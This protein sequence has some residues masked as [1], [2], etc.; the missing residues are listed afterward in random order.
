MTEVGA[1]D[2]IVTSPVIREI[3][4]IYPDAHV[5]ILVYPR[6]LELAEYCPYVNAIVLNDQKY[7]SQN[8]IE[9]YELNMNIARLFLAQRFDICFAT[10]IHSRTPLLMYMSGAKIRITSIDDESMEQFNLTNDLTRYLMRLSTHLF[11]YNTYGYHRVDRHLS[12]IEN[13]LHLPITNRNTEIWCK[14]DEVT[15]AK[16]LLRRASHPIHAFSM[17]SESYRKSYPPEKYVRLLE[18]ILSEE[19]TAT[20]VILGGGQYDLNSAEIIKKALPKV[21]EN[22]IIDLTNKINYRQ[23]ATVI[24][25]CDM[26]IGNDTCSMH[27]A[28]AVDIPVLTPN[29]FAADFPI[30]NTDTPRRWYPYGVPSVIVQPKHAM[31]ECKNLDHYNPYGCAANFPHCITQIEPETLFKAFKQ[32]KKRVA[33]GIVEPLYMS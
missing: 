16:T 15:F 19:P 5:T 18:M 4:R 22:H 12:L 17:G 29:C 7:S 10:T 30:R 33:A 3:R 32:L 1:G 9:I 20:F 6:S 26:Y 2:F 24:S 14:P 13:L 8:L 11:P 25:F 31:P 21:Y 27:M 28:A 23:S